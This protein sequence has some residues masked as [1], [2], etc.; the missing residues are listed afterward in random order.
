M[1]EVGCAALEMVQRTGLMWH[2]GVGGSQHR[3]ASLAAQG[4][5]LT[6]HV[7]MRR[8]GRQGRRRQ[9]AGV[10]GGAGGAAQDP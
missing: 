4:T 1:V 2:E 9:A 6:G 3:R 10:A 5:V 7:V 8:Q